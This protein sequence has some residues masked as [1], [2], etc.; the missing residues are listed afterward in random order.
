MWKYLEQQAGLACMGLVWS[1][2]GPVGEGRAEEE[3]LDDGSFSQSAEHVR[4]A[5]SRDGRLH[6]AHPARRNE[7][8]KPG[9]RHPRG[10]THPRG[11]RPERPHHPKP[12]HHP[13]PTPPTACDGP[14]SFQA[15][16]SGQSEW[17]IGSAPPALNNLG[18]LAFVAVDAMGAPHLLLGDGGPLTAQNLAT[19]GFE[20]PVRVALDDAAN[21]AFLASTPSSGGLFGV[22]ATDTAGSSLLVHYAAEEGGGLA[23][24]GSIVA[25]RGLALAPNG[26][27][28]FSSIID[29]S[30]ALYRGPITGGASVL[31][32]G[33][34]DFF[35]RQEMDVNAGGTV[36]MQME[37]SACGLQRGV[38]AFD[39]PEPDIQDTNKAIAGL[40]VGQQPD[41]A[42]NDAGVMAFALTGTSPTTEV[43]RCPPGEPFVRF[44]IVTGVYTAVPTP[45]SDPPNLTLIVD[46]SGPF[47]SFGSIDINNAGNVVFEAE[48]DTGERGIFKGPDPVL[49][50]IVAVGD[51]LGG[52]AVTE[53]QLGQLNDACELSLATVSES[54]RSVW[55]IGG[56]T[57]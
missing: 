45:L 33:S 30:G 11:G 47:A 4:L 39:D 24:G 56:I 49:D 17:S 1:C 43:L 42:L 3:A 31:V 50:K 46:N 18:Q 14:L 37:H 57:P 32:T 55:R 9:R 10:G 5:H 16:A 20:P 51:E 8:S 6:D 29:A 35:N 25:S 15:V 23:D 53:V 34:S 44:N 21:L 26:T 48:L 12:P 28:A 38:L 19:L 41:H 22:F 52:E 7:W 36:T 2:S 54:G 40:N 13:P 27:L